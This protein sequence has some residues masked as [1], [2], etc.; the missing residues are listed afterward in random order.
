MTVKR[1]KQMNNKSVYTLR[2]QDIDKTKAELVGGKGANL[3]EISGIEGIQVPDGF[4]V[5]TEAYKRITENN[6]QLNGL[7]DELARLKAEDRKNISEIS[8]KIRLVIERI[9]NL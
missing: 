6:P 7:L 2:F 5:T 1:E 8:A 3:G 4:C 9:P